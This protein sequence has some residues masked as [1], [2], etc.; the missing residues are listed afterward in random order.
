MKIKLL[1]LFTDGKGG[2]KGG[3]KKKGGSF[4]TVS[5]LFRVMLIF[6]DTF[7][8]TFKRDPNTKVYTR[9]IYVVYQ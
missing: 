7:L 2:K 6:T 3:G 4:Q 9:S 5:A 1:M 8:V